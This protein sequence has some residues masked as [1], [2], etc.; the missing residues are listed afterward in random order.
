MDLGIFLAT[1][2]GI[3]KVVDLIRNTVDTSGKLPKATWNLVATVLGLVAAFVF[4]L[5]IVPA[6][7]PISQNLAQILT[8]LSLVGGASAGHEL[9]DYFS[10]KADAA[11]SASL[12]PIE[13]EQPK[14]L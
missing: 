6:S 13:P 7:V 5:N 12:A 9:M 10:S 8:G 14:G 4:E 1:A 11:K 3:T 2:A